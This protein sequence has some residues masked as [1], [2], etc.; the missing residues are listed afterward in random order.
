MTESV[1]TL[2]VAGCSTYWGSRGEEPPPGACE[3]DTTVLDYTAQ[4]HA[5]T[6]NTS[7]T[8]EVNVDALYAIQLGSRNLTDGISVVVV[9]PPSDAAVV[10]LADSTGAAVDRVAPLGGLVALAG[11]GSD[12]TVEAISADGLVLAA[13]PPDGVVH[14]GITYPC[15]LASDAVIPVTTTAI[16][17]GSAP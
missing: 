14:N 17:D 1:E 15:T 6:V 2:A 11:L 3:Q 4:R 12:L 7:V 16:D 13:C 10:R 5:E 8:G 9:L